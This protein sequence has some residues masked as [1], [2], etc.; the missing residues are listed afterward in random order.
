MLT[1][2][3]L[4]WYEIVLLVLGVALFLVLLLG[5]RRNLAAGK[6]YA[7]LLPFF[8][9]TIAM[10]GYPSIKSIQ[11]NNGMVEINTT[12][13]QI[14]KNPDDPANKARS[15]ELQAQL[16]RF[17]E[18]AGSEQDKA[19]IAKAREAV[20]LV[21]RNSKGKSLPGRE[22]QGNPEILERVSALTKQVEERPNEAALRQQLT[23]AVRQLKSSGGSNPAEKAAIERAEKVLAKP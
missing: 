1:L 21:E 10:I 22:T 16:N 23:E 6:S 20:M 11:Y 8:I 13:E 4:Y 12:A 19:T 5:L 18:R 7:G 14:A 15:V 17:A 2:G 9:L 3:G